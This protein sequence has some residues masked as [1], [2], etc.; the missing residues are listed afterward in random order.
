MPTILAPL[1]VLLCI[2]A[3]LPVVTG[4]YVVSRGFSMTDGFAAHESVAMGSALIIIE[5][6]GMVLPVVVRSVNES[7]V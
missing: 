4:V 5:V 2:N 3:I 6:V 7:V 1:P